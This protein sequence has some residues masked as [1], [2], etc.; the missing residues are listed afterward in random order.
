MLI[1]KAENESKRVAF[2]EKNEMLISPE[3]EIK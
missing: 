1:S 3:Y 2:L